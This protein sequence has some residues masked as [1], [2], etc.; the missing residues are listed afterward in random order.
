MESIRGVC[1]GYDAAGAPVAVSCFGPEIG[2]S[3]SIARS[4]CSR[5]GLSCREFKWGDPALELE[6]DRWMGVT[7]GGAG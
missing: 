1:I 4:M 7:L 3:R 5:D 6:M 2:T